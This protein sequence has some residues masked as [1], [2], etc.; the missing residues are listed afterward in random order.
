VEAL[1]AFRFIQAVGGCAASVT[2]M[3]M[4][5]DY[6][7]PKE[8]AKILSL[9]VLILGVSPLLAP[10]AGSFLTAHFGWQSVF[11]ALGVL[12]SL[13][14]ALAVFANIFLLQAGCRILAAGSY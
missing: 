7:S 12:G 11:I 1:I 13:I 6:F 9:L 10:T 4:V 5:R 8:S 14:L 2:A 3:A